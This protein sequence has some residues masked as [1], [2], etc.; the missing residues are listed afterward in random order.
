MDHLHLVETTC[1]E[2]NMGI[3]VIVYCIFVRR[4]EGTELVFAVLCISDFDLSKYL[5]VGY[6]R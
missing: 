6:A 3:D 1:K 2:E 5:F 4:I